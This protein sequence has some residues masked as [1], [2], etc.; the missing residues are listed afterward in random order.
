M[1]ICWI[2]INILLQ[3]S[4]PVSILNSVAT[5]TFKIMLLPYFYLIAQSKPDSGRVFP[6]SSKTQC[7]YYLSV[8][9]ISTN[10]YC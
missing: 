6:V 9:I 3:L 5:L 2:D 1:I 4:S 10:K 7:T 8:S